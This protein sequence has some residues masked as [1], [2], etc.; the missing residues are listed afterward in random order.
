MKPDLFKYIVIVGTFFL[1]MT[2]VNSVK[3]NTA[4]SSQKMATL[5]QTNEKIVRSFYASLGQKDMERIE[6]FLS[7]DFSFQNAMNGKRQFGKKVFSTWW[8]SMV[9]DATV[10]K[11]QIT[12]IQVMGNTVMFENAFYYQDA[13]ERMTF[14]GTNFVK[15]K[16][17]KITEYQEYKLPRL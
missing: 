1:T 14:R 13:N 6:Q 3:A 12:R 10:L 2:S 15:I 8:H 11:P 4:I 5:E 17:G 16:N 9:H 7:D